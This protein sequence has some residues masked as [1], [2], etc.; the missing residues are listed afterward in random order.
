MSMNK[1]NSVNLPDHKSEIKRINRII[2]QLEGIQRMITDNRYCIDI[3]VQSKAVGSAVKALE[4]SIL[5][6][7]LRTCL[8]DAFL[9]KND[10]NIDDKLNELITLYKK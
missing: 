6:K 2:G 9:T 10:K 7:H 5:E 8:K 4:S 1:N 3:L